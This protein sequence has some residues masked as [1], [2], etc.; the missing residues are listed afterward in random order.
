MGGLKPNVWPKSHGKGEGAGGGCAPSHGVR[1]LKSYMANKTY[2]ILSL[3]ILLTL[4]KWC[5]K[6]LIAI[7]RNQII[8]DNK[9]RQ[10]VV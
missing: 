5:N 9:Y 2:F 3:K 1:K 6:F 4:F 10:E 8:D 7:A